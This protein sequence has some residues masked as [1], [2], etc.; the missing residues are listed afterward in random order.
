MSCKRKRIDGKVAEEGQGVASWAEVTDKP[1]S[2]PPAA[3]THVA[4]DITDG[5]FVPLDGSQAM[6]GDLDMGEAE[7]K[8]VKAI[9]GK[10]LD[11]LDIGGNEY[12]QRTIVENKT[13]VQTTITGPEVFG[14]LYVHGG[15]SGSNGQLNLNATQEVL[16]PGLGGFTIPT[17][18]LKTAVGRP[19]DIESTTGPLRLKGS[20]VQV[21]GDV[22]QVLGPSDAFIVNI[23]TVEV[24]D[25]SAGVQ[26]FPSTNIAL[27]PIVGNP[28]GAFQVLNG[29][30]YVKQDLQVDGQIYCESINNIRPS[31]GV[32]AESSGFEAVSQAG[33]DEINILGRGSSAGSLSVPANTFRQFDTYAFKASGRLSG[34]TNDLFT[35]R[36]KSA[37]VEFGAI[38]IQLSDNGLV[39]VWWDIVADFT[40]R[41]IGG[42]GTAAL[43]LSGAFR[44]TNS[45]APPVVRTYGRTIVQDVLF[46]T[47]VG[48]TLELTFQNDGVN[49]LSA[50]YIDS[51][52]F[53]K[54]F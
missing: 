29:G 23:S 8:N 28:S 51:C 18:E 4:A 54:W 16:Y 43:V 52:S 2:F 9:R 39:E 1:L 7:I 13:I 26:V 41:Q 38:P 31:G 25:V 40:I 48:N 17:V 11:L 14:G 3:H 45:N 33:V 50:F 21:K 36:L 20:T 10:N 12:G 32:Y 35:L 15:I 37:G 22:V 53:T 5:P 46:D 42:P 24:G 49:P 30:A 27:P 47:T 19:L 6:T 34:G 44:Y